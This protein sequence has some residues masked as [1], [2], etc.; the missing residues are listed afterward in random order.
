MRRGF[1]HIPMAREVDAARRLAARENPLGRRLDL[2]GLKQSVQR[3]PLAGA[4]NRQ[5]Q[6]LS[7]LPLLHAVE[8]VARGRNGPAVNLHNQIARVKTDA[9]GVRSG[10]H[11][12]RPAASIHVRVDAQSKIIFHAPAQQ[13]AV[14]KIRFARDIAKPIDHQP[15][16]AVVAIGALGFPRQLVGKRIAR[17]VFDERLE[18]GALLRPPVGVVIRLGLHMEHHVPAELHEVLHVR[19]HDV[20]GIQAIAAGIDDKE[21]FVHRVAWKHFAV[22]A[23]VGAGQHGHVSNERQKGRPRRDVAK[24]EKVHARAPVRDAGGV[25]AIF[26]HIVRALQLVENLRQV[27]D[28]GPLP[29][30]RARP[31]GREHRNLFG[32][33][34]KAADA[35]AIRV[36]RLLAAHAAVQLHADPVLPRRIVVGRDDEGVVV[37]DAVKRPMVAVLHAAAHARRVIAAAAQPRN[38]VVERD[39]AFHDGI[40]AFARRRRIGRD[41]KVLE[42]PIDCRVGRRA[43]AELPGGHDR[44]RDAG[45]PSLVDHLRRLY[46]TRSPRRRLGI[47]A[48]HRRVL[49]RALLDDGDD[50]LC[51]ADKRDEAPD[52]VPPNAMSQSGT[53]G[54]GQTNAE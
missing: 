51:Q 52:R 34:R 20:R 27:V 29:P 3:S 33:A 8:H 28:L 15:V 16:R 6:A 9:I 41:E 48:Q 50:H 38:R 25:H 49:S 7:N 10:D 39:A 42:R 17:M 43:R 35:Q 18:G 53:K 11:V 45:Q 31:G 23:D 12:G 36:G 14:G 13:V 32:S 5:L 37:L 19:L 47:G 24:R 21:R 30:E 4:F 46:R 2:S 44:R 22:G 1:H 40:R 54:D 26:I